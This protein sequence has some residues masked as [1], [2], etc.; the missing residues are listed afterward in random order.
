MTQSEGTLAGRRVIVTGG[1]GGIGRAIV[2][3]FVREGASVGI[4]DLERDVANDVA[5]ELRDQGLSAE[6]AGGN[7]AASDE[8]R[9]AV[10]E[11]TKRLGGLDGCVAV[12]GISRPTPA[13]DITADGWN[14]VVGVNLGGVF[15]TVQAAIPH[16]LDA[17]KGSVV[18]I[19]SIAALGGPIGRAHYSSSK[20]GLVGLMKN[21]AIE[22]GPSGLRFNVVQPGHIDTKLGHHPDSNPERSAQTTPLRRLG[23]GEDVAGACAYLISD[24]SSYVT[25]QVLNVC[26]G[27]TLW[28]PGVS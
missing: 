26:G 27:K 14:E 10:D 11:L 18:A 4:L 22:F 8:A 19:G 17:K 20:A 1:A 6:A 12:A 21:L 3:R 13:L 5:A 16:F 15:F 23:T 25:G 2:E 24:E 9:S 7:V 28:S